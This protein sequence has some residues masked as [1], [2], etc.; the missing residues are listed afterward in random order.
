KAYGCKIESLSSGYETYIAESLCTSM[1]LGVI[2]PQYQ[3]TPPDRSSVYFFT[4]YSDPLK[5][6]VGDVVYSYA[7]TNSL[8]NSLWRVI[9]KPQRVTIS[10]RD[11]NNLAHFMNLQAKLVK[12]NRYYQLNDGWGGRLYGP[13]A[14]QF[15]FR[16]E[17]NANLSSGEYTGGNIQVEA[18]RYH[19]PN[20]G[21]T[22]T[23]AVQ[24]VGKIN[25]TNNNPSRQL[26]FDYDK[27]LLPSQAEVVFAL[28]LKSVPRSRFTL[29]LSGH[30]I[31]TF[32]KDK[33]YILDTYTGNNHFYK[34]ISKYNNI[35][36]GL[37]I[38]KGLESNYKNIVIKEDSNGQLYDYE[39]FHSD[40]ITTDNSMLSK[41]IEKPFYELTGSE[42]IIDRVTVSHSV[43]FYHELPAHERHARCVRPNMTLIEELKEIFSSGSAICQP[44]PASD[45]YNASRNSISDLR[46]EQEL[47]EAAVDKAY[48][49][50]VGYHLLERF[51]LKDRNTIAFLT[52]SH[53]CHVPVMAQVE[54]KR[55]KRSPG[56]EGCL[57]WTSR[58]VELYVI[59]GLNFIDINNIVQ[60]IINN[61]HIPISLF[62][63]S[64]Y[65]QDS[66]AERQELI[67][68]ISSHRSEAAD[69]LQQAAGI[70]G[71]AAMAST[72]FL[73]NSIGEKASSKEVQQAV[74]EAPLGIYTLEKQNFSPLPNVVK[75][76]NDNGEPE[77]QERESYTTEII[78]ISANEITPEI[79]T[80]VT[81]YHEIIKQW[82]V[83]LKDKEN[84]ENEED[85]EQLELG[86]DLAYHIESFLDDILDG[87]I[88]TDFVVG[89]VYHN[90][91]L[92]G[93]SLGFFEYENSIRTYIP[94]AGLVNPNSLLNVSGAYRGAIA[95]LRSEVIK[96]LFKDNKME[97]ST[98][99]CI[100]KHSAKSVCRLG[101]RH[102]EL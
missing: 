21:S 48:D 40:N 27:S 74:S 37:G 71:M 24:P 54:G 6:S 3:V 41:T 95:Y 58:M 93:I 98:A 76:L 69:V 97:K 12:N 19:D 53:Y 59:L 61:G 83:H 10:V 63:N 36:I 39:A 52:S 15:H 88:D 78:T 50:V 49:D 62:P 87:N 94:E 57:G 55:H 67:S 99:K 43:A 31:L 44:K 29:N 91:N 13:S 47:I 20:S 70:T 23:H 8:F 80:T 5:A 35:T 45:I 51:D 64:Q 26:T 14:F 1:L 60:N 85:R 17:D 65:P 79:R 16:K 4:P 102:D 73:T 101:F 66:E 90:H 22:I 33:I 86:L 84:N 92:I 46:L 75:I 30:Y 34:Y 56:S 38:S 25:V 18:A 7:S 68:V 96:K 42:W 2:S 89:G 9:A 72:D 28:R 82:I 11:E 100:S 77:V 32:T 81:R